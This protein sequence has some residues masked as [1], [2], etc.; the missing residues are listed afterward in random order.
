[1][2]VKSVKAEAEEGCRFGRCRTTAG[3]PDSYLSTCFSV[4]I[5]QID[6]AHPSKHFVSQYK[7]KEKGDTAP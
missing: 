3:L 7:S 2:L 1:M 6:P 5:L 4:Y